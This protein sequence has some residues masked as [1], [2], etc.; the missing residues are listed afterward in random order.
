MDRDF[1]R[2]I[3]LEEVHGDLEPLRPE[4][5]DAEHALSLDRTQAVLLGDGRYHLD[6]RV[7]ILGTRP[8]VHR[9]EATRRTANRVVRRGG[10]P[11]RS[12]TSAG[13]E[14]MAGGTASEAQ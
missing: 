5:R 8:H 7:W 10:K 2:A 6:R 9:R 3:R 13:V 12:S 11:P 4:P 14:P 1:D